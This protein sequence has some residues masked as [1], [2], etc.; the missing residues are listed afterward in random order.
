MVQKV[1]VNANDVGM[2]K[3]INYGVMEEYFELD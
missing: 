1:I 3:G 2:S